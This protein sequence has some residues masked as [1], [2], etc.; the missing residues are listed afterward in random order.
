VQ[1]VN[2]WH[3]LGAEGNPQG[4]GEDAGASRLAATTAARLDD[5]AA[6]APGIAIDAIPSSPLVAQAKPL[7]AIVEATIDK[8]ANRVARRCVSI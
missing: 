2:D 4:A 1:G 8:V 7:V 6:E 3:P 5:C